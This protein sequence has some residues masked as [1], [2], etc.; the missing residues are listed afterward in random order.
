MNAG[1]QIRVQPVVLQ[2]NV[3]ISV[4]STLCD[5]PKIPL[6]CPPGGGREK[7]RGVGVVGIAT[8]VRARLG[9]YTWG[10]KLVRINQIHFVKIK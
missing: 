7:G 8:M 2:Y 1:C 4:H 5:Y 3:S 6:Q 10:K 9:E